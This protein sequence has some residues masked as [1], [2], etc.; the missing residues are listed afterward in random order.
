MGYLGQLYDW[1]SV[2]NEVTVQQRIDFRR[3][4]VVD[5]ERAITAVNE[6]YPLAGS[7]SVHR[8]HLVEGFFR[9]LQVPQSHRGN[10]ANSVLVGWGLMP[11]V[12]TSPLRFPT[13]P[14]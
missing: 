6:L 3:N 7:Q 4:Q 9:D 11:S 12:R 5:T 10:A 1:V 14:T 2:G 8:R 13:N